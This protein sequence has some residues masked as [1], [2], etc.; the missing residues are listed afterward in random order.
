ME[1][2]AE[3]MKKKVTLIYDFLKEL[4]GLERV[5]FFQA[6]SLKKRY[7]VEIAFSYVSDF[8]KKIICKEFGLKNSIPIKKIHEG[9][10]EI[11]N[12]MKSILFPSYIKNIKT[13][14]IVSHSFMSSRLAL[15]KKEKE[16]VP[17]IVFLH[18][19]PNFL[20]D[21]NKLW[22]NNL[23]RLIA[24]LTGLIFFPIFR[25]LDIKT[26]KKADKVIV[27]SDYT[28]RRIEKIYSV[29]AE[30]IYPPISKNLRPVALKKAKKIIEKFEI[31]KDFI[32]MHGRMIRDKR[33]DLGIRAFYKLNKEIDLIISGT[34]EE[35]EKII[36]LIHDLKLEK[37]VKILGRVS[38]EE[39]G[40]LYS[41][42]KCFIMPSPKEDF[43]LTVVEAMRCGCPVIAW[44]D[45]AGPQEIIK[46]NING[47]LAEPYKIEKLSEK[48]EES[49]KKRWNKQ[50][51]SDSVKQFSEQQIEK[52]FIKIVEE[53]LKKKF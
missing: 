41:L 38:E 44:K 11:L 30:V 48:I 32:L 17:Y 43:G 10:K 29:K 12:Y 13:S 51:I 36:K 45:N 39:L 4:G 19:P 3:K 46:D 6:N 9:N 28:R 50:E 16:R 7:D 27:N 20:Y 15:I 8:H 2:E 35:K 26:I 14:L 52:K 21:R 33:P 53:V 37:S 47:M 42:A 34:I 1:N 49:L 40:A 5:I 18:H 25:D 23:P 24:Y 31:R 22:V